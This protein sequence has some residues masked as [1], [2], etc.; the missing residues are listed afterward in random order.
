[1]WVRRGDS[2]EEAAV[3][4]DMKESEH[5]GGNL[6]RTETCPVGSGLGFETIAPPPPPPCW[7]FCSGSRTALS[8]LAIPSPPSPH[9]RSFHPRRRGSMSG[10]RGQE[11]GFE[12]S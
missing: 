4:T 6:D 7:R 12:G 2:R 1:M 11:E 3:N 8:P 10:R 9:P 5:R